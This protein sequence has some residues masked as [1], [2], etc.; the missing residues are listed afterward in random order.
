MPS[1][2]SLLCF[3]FSFCMFI[4]NLSLHRNQHDFQDG[5][6]LITLNDCAQPSFSARNETKNERL[7]SQPS[8]QREGVYT[9]LCPQSM[10]VTVHKMRWKLSDMIQLWFFE[11]KTIELIFLNQTVWFADTWRERFTNVRVAWWIYKR[12]QNNW[13][14]EFIS[15]VC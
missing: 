8:V 10:M 9:A 14:W 15:W 3:L 13:V 4:C 2:A 12:S 6:P 11:K 7:Q 1:I 5:F